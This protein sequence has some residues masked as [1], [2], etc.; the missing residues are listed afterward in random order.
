MSDTTPTAPSMGV[1]SP[2]SDSA[3]P[4]PRTRVR[5]NRS[6][7][8]GTVVPGGQGRIVHVRYD[9]YT[10]EFPQ[11][12]GLLTVVQAP[13]PDDLLARLAALRD[14]GQT[15]TQIAR[16]LNQEGWHPP[17]RRARCRKRRST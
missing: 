10:G 12:V 7:D 6:G 13:V 2:M 3:R 9:E 1:V 4:A 14:A 17:K 8:V 15:T 16:Q 11:F 5:H